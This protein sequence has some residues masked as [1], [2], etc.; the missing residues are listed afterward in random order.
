VEFCQGRLARYKIPKKIEFS[1]SLPYS[2][3]GKVIKS[4][5]RKKYLG[6]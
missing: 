2:P 1:Q 6:E 3:Y 4:E 5:L